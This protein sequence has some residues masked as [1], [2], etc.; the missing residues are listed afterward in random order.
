MAMMSSTTRVEDP[1]LL[2]FFL[3]LFF[4]SPATQQFPRILFITHKSGGGRGEEVGGGV[5]Y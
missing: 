3:L 4:L 1:W 5:G 2:L